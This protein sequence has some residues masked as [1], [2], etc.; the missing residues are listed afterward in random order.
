MPHCSII[1]AQLM[2]IS[3]AC[4]VNVWIAIIIVIAFSSP[5]A[6]TRFAVEEAEPGCSSSPAAEGVY[7]LLEVTVL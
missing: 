5:F 2:G 1:F 6:F 7:S 3:V 4:L